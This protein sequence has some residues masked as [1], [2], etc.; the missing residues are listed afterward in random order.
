MCPLG[1]GRG[2]RVRDRI[3]SSATARLS[4]HARVISRSRVRP[5]LSPEIS[6][7]LALGHLAC[8]RWVVGE[9][10]RAI[11]EALAT[12]ELADQIQIP[13]LQA[14]GHV[15]LGR[16]RYLRRDPLPVVE[17]EALHAVRA[18]SLDLGLFTE[19]SAFALW[20]EA[21]RGPLALAAIEPLL[22]SLQRRLTE[23]STCSTLVAQVLIDV[24]RI[25]G[26]AARAREL[27]DEIIAFAI[28]H[29][30]RVYLPELIR[31]RGE[32]REA[33]S[34]ESAARDYRE[35]IELAR[36]TGARS[37]EPRAAQSLAALEA[38]TRH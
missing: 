31:V 2:R 35:A 10:E 11:G 25:S 24:L 16:L 28:S 21:Q 7:A 19:A 27:T 17:E 1:E 6:R 15:V 14:L 36:S 8:A 13:I 34:P 30:E 18:A 37:L 22:D 32:Q 12:I 29:H 4:S 33:A 5:P 9:P 38:G 3:S 23:V 26:H 20:A